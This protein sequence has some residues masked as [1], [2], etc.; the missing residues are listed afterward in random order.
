[1]DPMRA[2]L[3]LLLAVPL[4]AQ[5]PQLEREELTLLGWNDACSVAVKHHSYPTRGT[6]IY[7]EPIGTRLGTMTIT[8]GEQAQKARWFYEASGPNTYDAARIA[9]IEKDLRK[10]G[11]KRKG[12]PET[13]RPDP[14]RAQPGL[15][16]TILTTAT[17]NLRGGL[18]WPGKEWRW[19]GADYS[20]LGT[21]ALLIFD[22]VEAPPRKAWLMARTYNPR[23][24][25][26]RSRAHAANARLLFS[27]GELEAAT[28]EAG[29][30]AALAPEAALSRYVHAALLAMSGR[31]DKAV[32]ELRAAIALDPRKRQEAR[33]DADFESLRARRDFR[34]LVGAS[35]LDRMTR[36]R[37]TDTTGP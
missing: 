25:L 31:D 26:E 29:T 35:I 11:Y 20:P 3:P 6:A 10:L 17:L 33:E 21:C 34:D 8:P 30:A 36:E 2:L 28:A 27:A 7:G 14:S 23:L 5:E 16:E 32:A 19:S 9:R 4:A 37:G 22:S 24:R 18:A 15:A 12:Y 1:M 13:V